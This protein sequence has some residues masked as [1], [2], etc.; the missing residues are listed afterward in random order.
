[1]YTPA[2]L[3]FCPNITISLRFYI[4]LSVNDWNKILLNWC[5][6]FLNQKTTPAAV[7]FHPNTT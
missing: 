7:K 6:F 2:A 1:M 3:K 4:H 5:L